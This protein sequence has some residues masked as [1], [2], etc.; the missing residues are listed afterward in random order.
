MKQLE[1][2]CKGEHTGV[3][4]EHVSAARVFCT[5]GGQSAYVSMEGQ[6]DR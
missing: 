6:E 1:H 4:K 3:R 2:R 5:A